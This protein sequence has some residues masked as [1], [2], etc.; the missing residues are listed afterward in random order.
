MIECREH[1]RIPID[2]QILF[3]MT[4]QTDIRQGTLFDISTGGCAVISGVSM[5]PGTGVKL[6]IQ[7]T[8]LA[9]PITVHSAAVRWA[10]HGEFGVE[11]LRLTDLDRSRLQ[12]LLHVATRR[13]P[14]HH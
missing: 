10:T 11:F 14:S 5:A 8:E 9:V 3:S 13:P 1:P 2:L 6:L 4:D 12:R 7:A